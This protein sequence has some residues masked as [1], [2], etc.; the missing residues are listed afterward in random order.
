MSAITVDIAVIGAGTAGLVALR[1]IQKRTDRYVLIQDGPLGTT[2]ARVGCMPSKVLIQTAE[3]FHRRTFLASKGIRGADALRVEGVEVMRHVRRL[4]DHFTDGMVEKTLRYGDKLI[5]GRARFLDTHR[6]EADG[7]IIEARRIII[8]TGSRPM[9]PAQW[10]A[11]GQRLLTSDTI[12]ELETLPKSLAV[13]G[14][15]V[16]GV[17]LGQAMAR[18]GVEVVGVARSGRIAGLSDPAVTESAVKAFSREFDLWCGHPAEIAAEGSR[19]TVT[20]GP[21]RKT[22]EAVLVSVGRIPNVDDLGLERLGI[23]L[24]ESGIPQYNPDTL[25]V[26]SL[27]IFIAGDANARDP[28]LHE[29][30]DDGRVAGYNAA[31]EEPACFK[32][33]TPLNITFCHSNIVVAGQRFD[34]LKESNTIIGQCRFD[35]QGRAVI[36]DQNVGLMRIYADPRTGRLL[37]TEM[38][39]PDGEHLGHLLA[40]A[41][42]QQLTVFEA[43]RLPFY[44]PVIEEGLRTALQELAAQVRD[45]PHFPEMAFCDESPL[46][47]LS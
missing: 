3:D 44:H 42:Q 35:Q 8:A 1:E 33:R 30:W 13:I 18:L 9:V 37:G 7:H 14:M 32:R 22:V 10:K 24:N 43:L 34:Q 15:G 38:F 4:R 27:P 19:F 26:G 16:I 46:S 17:E 11:F 5:Y 23:P 28:I 41:I 36:L 31:H 12:F 21:H 29:A 45:K 6:L 25:Q 40:W 20:A 47:S 39:A 2:C